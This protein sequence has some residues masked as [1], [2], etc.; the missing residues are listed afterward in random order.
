MSENGENQALLI[1]EFISNSERIRNQNA[2]EECVC[3]ESWHSD[4]W[5][6]DSDSSC[7]SSYCCESHSGYVLH[8]CIVVRKKND[9]L[10][11]YNKI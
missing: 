9:I 7:S 1:K 6:G 3:V 5:W 10:N 2:E 11:F 8:H 4:G